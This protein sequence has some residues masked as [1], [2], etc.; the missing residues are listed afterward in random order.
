MQHKSLT[1]TMMSI[2]A[3]RFVW[4]TISIFP[5]CNYLGKKYLRM[6]R[7]DIETGQGAQ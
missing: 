3:R 2:C 5:T 4:V 7:W 1:L 6:F